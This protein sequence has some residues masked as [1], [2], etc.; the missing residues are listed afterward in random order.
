MLHLEGYHGLSSTSN[1]FTGHVSLDFTN[2]YTNS[3]GMMTVQTHCHL[4]MAKLLPVQGSPW[5]ACK[6][7]GAAERLRTPAAPSCKSRKVTVW[8]ES[9][10]G[11]EARTKATWQ[12]QT[13]W[14]RSNSGQ[15][16]DSRPCPEGPSV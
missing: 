5:S 4:L 7:V 13:K 3:K 6:K 1:S 10:T 2:L 9:L 8:L 16:L 14:L 15:E 12:P 11:P